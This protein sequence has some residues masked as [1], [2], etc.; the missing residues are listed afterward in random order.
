MQAIGKHIIIKTIEE[1]VTTE[2]GLLLSGEETSK[3]RYRKGEI[4]NA[5]TDVSQ[6]K[7]GDVIYYDQS[8]GHTM[9]LNNQVVDI[10]LEAHV[11]VVL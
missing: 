10:I 2:S 5:G 9:L 7:T 11:V 1:E 4:L 8:G 6:L 3:L